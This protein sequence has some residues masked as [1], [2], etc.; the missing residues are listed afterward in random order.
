MELL[1]F[2]RW[3]RRHPVPVVVGVLIAGVVGLMAMRGETKTFGV[4]TTRLVVDT[5]NSQL[6]NP[7]PKGAETLPW[8][9][10]ILAELAATDSA[11]ARIARDMRVRPSSIAAISTNLTDP[12]TP[13]LLSGHALEAEADRPEPYLVAVGF[14]ERL[15]IITIATTAP[16][17]AQATR[18]ANAAATELIHITSASTTG[19]NPP[20]IVAERIGPPRSKAVVEQPVRRLGAFAFA[21]VFTLWCL[22]FALL[23]RLWDLLRPPRGAPASPPQWES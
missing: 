15:P 10:G 7:A 13:S 5:P 11:I 23:S 8:R 18:L 4:A 20:G 17:R 9:S 14:D 22:G 1:A 21:V 19:G 6:L 12:E 16:D 3:L 2:G